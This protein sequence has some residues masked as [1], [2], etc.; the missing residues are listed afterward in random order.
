MAPLLRDGAERTAHVAA[1]HAAAERYRWD[2]TAQ[3]LVD[4]Y[5][6]VLAAAP[7]ELRRAPRER[8]ALEQRLAE[9]ERLRVEEWQR[10]DAFREPIGSDGLR[11]RRARRRARRRRPARA[12]CAAVQARAA[13]T[14][15]EARARGVPGG[16]VRSAARLASRLRGRL[17]DHRQ[18][19]RRA[20]SC[21]GAL[22]R[23][24]PSRR[25]LPRAGHRRHRGL[26][27]RRRRAVHRRQPARARHRRLRADGGPVRRGRAVDRRQAVAHALA[28]R[29]QRRRRGR[30]PGPGHAPVRAAGRDV[31]GGPRARARADAAQRRPDAARRHA[32]QRA[33]HPHRRRVQPRL[34]RH[35]LGRLRRQAAGLV[36]RA[37]EDRL[38][39]RPDARLLRRP[40]L[41]RPR[42]R[43]GRE[44]P[45]PARPRLQRRV[46]EP[47]VAADPPRRGRGWL[48]GDVPLRLFHFSGF[49]H[50]HPHAALQAPEPHP[51]RRART[52]SRRSAEQ[53]ATELL[54]AGA[55]DAR[56]AVHVRDDR[57]GAAAQRRH[58]QRL[59]QARRSRRGRRAV[60]RRAGAGVPRAPERARAGRARRCGRHHD[61]LAALYE[62]RED[63]RR[64]YPNL[65]GV[66]TPPATSAGRAC[67]G[68][69][70]CPAPLCRRRGD[71]AAA[72]RQTRRP[73]RASR[74]RSASTSPAT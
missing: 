20:R 41:D 39:R 16:D 23:R 27:R 5:E 17:H 46:L 52:T 62:E 65:A 53:Y 36:G 42:A 48:A 14:A 70:R 1:L 38:H 29:A 24:A 51:A 47:V 19:L 9:N 12:A 22:V 15:D 28:A 13:R 40:A 64:A 57:V 33:G 67:T 37:P 35:R 54:A 26:R 50:T 68:A 21:A 69:A 4:L 58:A 63:L 55:D 25:P 43:D 6:Q 3:A 61:Y 30:V 45:P 8:L 18:E 72:H 10:H 2:D 56:V 7:S 71:D 73:A 59:S 49:D 11:S 34:H 31:R 60:R 44:L 74:T 66:A 32:A